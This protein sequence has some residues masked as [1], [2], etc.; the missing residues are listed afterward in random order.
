MSASALAP[1]KTVLIVD[2]DFDI[3]NVLSD[4]LEEA[5]YKVIAAADGGEALRHLRTRPLPGLILL[6]LLMPGMDGA[7]FRAE[8]CKDP[9][10][11][12]IPVVLLTA[13]GKVQEKHRSMGVVAALKKP[14]HID[15]LVN[16]VDRYCGHAIAPAPTLLE[17][18]PQ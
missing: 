1:A 6:D 2:D 5:G 4:V 11:S 14:M 3:R 16:T 12:K 10:L 8:Q 18:S 13:D 17:P 9:A 7:T 15:D